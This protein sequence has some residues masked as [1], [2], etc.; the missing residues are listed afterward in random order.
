MYLHTLVS[1]TST[2]T[3]AILRAKNLAGLKLGMSQLCNNILGAL[4]QKGFFL[5]LKVFT[6]RALRIHQRAGVEY[7]Q[8]NIGNYDHFQQILLK[9][10]TRTTVSLKP[11]SFT[12]VLSLSIR[13]LI[14]GNFSENLMTMYLVQILSLPAIIYQIEANVSESLQ[15]FHT[16]SIFERSLRLLEKEQNIRIVTNS[17]KGCQTLA[18]LANL[19]H[20]FHM[21]PI[22]SATSLS[23]PTFTVWESSL[24]T[25]QISQNKTQSVQLSGFISIL[26]S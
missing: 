5:H 13:P 22:E 2:N 12:A 23:F 20:L 9:G 6:A 19:T 3:W 7:E 26:S 1:F 21:E 4:V 15:M 16:H 8:L 14:S 18:L 10:T 25:K 17:L 11:I 24:I